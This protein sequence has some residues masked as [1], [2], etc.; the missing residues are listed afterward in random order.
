MAS[1]VYVTVIS[2]VLRIQQALKKKKKQLVLLYKQYFET[3][4][5]SN[6]YLLDS[7]FIFQR[8]GWTPRSIQEELDF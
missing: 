8:N 1:T 7:H 2:G 5:F 4:T 3:V 6:L